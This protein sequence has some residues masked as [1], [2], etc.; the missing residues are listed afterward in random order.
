MV[1]VMN[2]SSCK[3]SGIEKLAGELEIKPHEIICIGALGNDKQMIGYVGLGV[4]M[5]NAFV[6][7]KKNADY[8]IIDQFYLGIDK[9][10]QK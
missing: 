1:E 4:V 7:I 5:G 8:V 6:E 9:F 10:Y 2:K 3:R